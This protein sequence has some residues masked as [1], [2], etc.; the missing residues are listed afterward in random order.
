MPGTK[1][2]TRMPY[3]VS[4]GL[5]EIVAPRQTMSTAQWKRLKDKFN[6]LCVFCGSGPTNE[7]RGIVPDHLIP[8]TRFGELVMGNTVPACQTCNDSRGDGDWR[9]FLR[10]R[11]PNNPEAQIKCVETYLKDH[12]YH[13]PSPET[14]L[15][16]EEQLSYALLL[17]DWESLLDKAST[18]HASAENR[19]MLHAND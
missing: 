2:F 3:N 10:G 1:H 5:R 15:S 9:P 12:P 13:P 17:K 11:F 18:L 16:Q 19:R 6:G 7:N 14:A 8:V 4:R